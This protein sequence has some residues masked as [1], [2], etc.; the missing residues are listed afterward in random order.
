[1]HKPKRGTSHFIKPV[2]STGSDSASRRGTR[3]RRFLHRSRDAEAERRCMARA[4]AESQAEVARVPTAHA[5]AF[6]GARR[7]AAINPQMNVYIVIYRIAYLKC[8]CEKLIGLFLRTS[9]E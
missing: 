6:K 2:L 4:A 7:P 8:V 5:V 9:D 1:M 3:L